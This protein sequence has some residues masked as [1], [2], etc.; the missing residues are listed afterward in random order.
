MLESVGINSSYNS[1]DQVESQMD[2]N[3]IYYFESQTWNLDLQ[4]A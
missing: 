3:A 2:S 4:P 1:L